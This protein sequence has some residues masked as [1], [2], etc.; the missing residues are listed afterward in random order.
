MARV[1]PGI[2]AELLQHGR[3]RA[4][5]RRG[6]VRTEHL[7]PVGAFECQV[8]CQR[9]QQA[10][11]ARHRPGRKTRQ[12]DQRVD[13][14]APLRRA[15]QSVQ[16]V[17]N[18]R[19]LDLAQIG[20]EP[21]Q[22]AVARGVVGGPR[23]PQFLVQAFPQRACHDVF[24]QQA[25]TARVERQGLVVLVHLALDLLQ[26]AI[27]LGARHR[28]H[29]VIDDHGLGAPLGLAA[30]ARVVDDE[31]VEV[32]QRAEDGVGPAGRAQ[33][34]ALARQPFEVAVRAD[35]HHRID[36]EGAAQPEVERQVVVRRHQVG[37]V[38]RRTQVHVAS[39]R[40]LDA[41]KHMTQAQAGDRE[42]IAAQGRV[43]F[44]RA[45]ACVDGRAAVH[46]QPIEVFQIIGQRKGL[47][48]RPR[49]VGGA[50]V[51]DAAQQRS[52][53]RIAAGRHVA[54]G[55]AGSLQRLQHG[56]G[57]GRRV[58][59]DA[60]GDARIVDRVVGQQ[61]RNTLVRVGFVAQHAPTSRQ[62]GHECHALGFG[63]VVHHVEL[64]VIAT[65]GHPLEA[66]DTREDAPVDLGQHHL[67]GQVAWG[68]AVRVGQPLV[69]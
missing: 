24:A 48:S 56:H 22:Q 23:Q 3:T 60:I 9:D 51:G 2:V 29:Q 7:E 12:R 63:L 31:G 6:P 13:A 18:L 28:R 57:G 33:R 61:Q 62:F 4:L 39:A 1:A 42:A 17:A 68:Q 5:P 37:V 64:G 25:R 43:V 59:A 41:D 69:L 47:G 15:A 44:R 36:R 65:P 53:Q 16:P 19:L 38:V 45:P 32:R 10:L 34:H 54:R 8:L 66:D 30:F 26:R 49:V 35:V 11:L 52:D 14:L 58:E 55:V 21:L 50:V 40:G 67:H 27:G 46:G 20:V